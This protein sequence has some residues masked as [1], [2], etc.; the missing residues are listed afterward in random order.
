[1]STLDPAVPPVSPL[2]LADRMLTLAQDAE[3]AGYPR[4]A[5][6]LVAALLAVLD[7]RPH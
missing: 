7:R 6:T 4:T 1:M 2:V 5:K 3:R